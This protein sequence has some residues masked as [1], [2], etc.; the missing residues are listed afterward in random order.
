MA[1]TESHMMPLKTKAPNFDLLDVVS[2]K[3][4]ALD[5][6]SSDKGTVIVFMCNH[7]PFVKYILNKLVEVAREY[8]EKGI[9]FIAIN[10]NDTIRFPADNPAH[11][12]EL[13]QENNFSFPYL[14]DET[15]EVAK[16]YQA[17]CT[18][19]FYVFDGNLECVYRG[20]FDDA[21]PQTDTP[22]TGKDLKQAL[23]CLLKGK[24][25]PQDQKPS[26][27]CNIKWK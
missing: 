1:I 14:Y 16:S 2:E 20:Q 21:R 19:D 4:Y 5:Q 13:A 10:S 12:K 24:P 22:V 27:G 18:P 8:K 23:D 26:I 17:A 25:V 7:C 11:M 9:S 3:M 6:L 15:Q